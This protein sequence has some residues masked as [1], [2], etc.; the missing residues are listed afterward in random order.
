MT[1]EE[2]EKEYCDFCGTQRCGGVNDKEWRE[3]C[4][5]CDEYN[6]YEPKI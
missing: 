4:H 3:G 5:Y 2:F 1:K 6:G